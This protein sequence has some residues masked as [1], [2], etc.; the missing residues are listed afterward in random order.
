MEVKVLLVEPVKT[1]QDKVED[2]QHII[3]LPPGVYR[4]S[5]G[6]TLHIEDYDVQTPH[7]RFVCKPAGPVLVL[8]T[9]QLSLRRRNLLSSVQL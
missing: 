3:S 1:I 7:C 6:F 5:M 8:G 9:N 4:V 2:V